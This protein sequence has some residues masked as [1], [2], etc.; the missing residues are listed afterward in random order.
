MDI[1]YY[2]SITT[3]THLSK[4]VEKEI[5]KIIGG[6]SVFFNFCVR[7]S[8]DEL[9]RFFEATRVFLS[10]RITPLRRI[11]EEWGEISFSFNEE[12]LDDTNTET[13]FERRFVGVL[14]RLFGATIIKI[15]PP[16]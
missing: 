6:S 4:E 13:V 1:Q 5:Q 10:D 2:V 8:D 14:E 9:S 12:E 11:N 16:L 7:L 15:N 3:P